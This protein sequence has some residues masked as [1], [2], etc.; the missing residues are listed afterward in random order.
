MIRAPVPTCSLMM[1]RAAIV[2]LCWAAVPLSSQAGASQRATTIQ[3]TNV[4]EK[5]EEL[6]WACELGKGWA[7]CSDHFES[8]SVPVTLQGTSSDAANFKTAREYIDWMAGVAMALGPEKAPIELK[9]AGYDAKRH[10]TVFS[11]VFGTFLDYVYTFTYAPATNK[12]V[13]MRTVWNDDYFKRER[14]KYF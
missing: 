4:Q 3:M 6:F 11:A 9:A 12:C 1:P 2:P 13:D 10:T 14:S 5:S 8:G 7:G